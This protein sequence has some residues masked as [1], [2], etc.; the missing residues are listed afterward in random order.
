MKVVKV[1][2]KDKLKKLLKE[3]ELKDFAQPNTNLITFT[4]YDEDKAKNKNFIYG[5]VDGIEHY[6]TFYVENNFSV[7]AMDKFKVH[8]PPQGIELK[9]I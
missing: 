9:Q 5:L 6:A 4:A 1:T 8:I 2:S 3:K 7:Y